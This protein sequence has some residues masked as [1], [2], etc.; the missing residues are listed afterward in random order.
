M[1]TC[2]ELLQGMGYVYRESPSEPFLT[3]EEGEVQEQE[4]FILIGPGCEFHSD[5]PAIILSTGTVYS[6]V[7]SKMKVTDRPFSESDPLVVPSTRNSGMQAKA[8]SEEAIERA[9]FPDHAVLRIFDVYG[10]G[11]DESRINYYIE[12]LEN[13]WPLPVEHSLHC[14]RSCLYLEDFKEVFCKFATQFVENNLRGLY[15]VGSDMP[16]SSVHLATSV[17]QI[18]HS[19]G[20]ASDEEPEKAVVEVVSVP[21]FVNFHEVPD[22]TR[23]CAVT[24][25]KIST[26]LRMGIFLTISGK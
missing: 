18:W 15:N 8:I 5:R 16:V 17:S 19:K 11:M 25:W 22:I 3:P 20:V 14:K 1:D 26:S 24:G 9:A 6:C 10:K 12:R 2:R 7:D 23:I 4:D 13:G 21:F